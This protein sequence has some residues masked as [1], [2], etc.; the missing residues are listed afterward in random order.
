[1][2]KKQ[3][4]HFLQNAP[5]LLTWSIIGSAGAY[6]YNSIIFKY[7]REASTS[8]SRDFFLRMGFYIGV[9][10]VSIPLTLLFDR[11]F[12]NN[13]YVNKLYGKDI[14]NKDILTKAQM[15]KSGQA[16]FYIALLLFTT[17]SWW[18]FDT[19]GGNFNSWYR[20]YGQHL[21][22]LRSSSE[23]ARV[24]S[25]HSLASSGNSK[26][27]LMK[28]FADRL[29][30]GTKN[31][32]L[33]I[34]WLAGSNSLKHPDI[35]KEIQNGIKSNDASIKNNSILALTRIMEVPGIETVRF[36]EEELKKYLTA[37]KKP[38]VQ[39]V[40]A[41]AFLRTT[42]FINLFIDMFKINDETLSV[43]LS[44]AL[45]WVSGPTP[46]QISRIIRQLKHNISKGSERLK[47]MTTIALT[48]MAQSLDDESLA[49]LRREF[50]AKSSD[51]RCNPE[52]FSLHF[53]EKK[54]D[55]I[56]ITKL[57]IRGFTYPAHG[58]VHYR[59]RIL[60]ILALNRDDSM[61]PW[62]E[63][64]ANNENINEYLRGLAKQAAKR[65][66]NENQIADW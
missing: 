42:E 57:T 28:I 18:S 23:K 26:P 9:F 58:K 21:T 36:I 8:T 49:I 29:K 43:I 52:V 25:L 12:N 64:M 47:C 24:K 38:P 65:N 10:L 60:R 46:I 63:R 2:E 44:Y 16:Q 55:T 1:M 4:V 59:E 19:L 45:V 13:R 20:K 3:K 15:I 30:K 56:N 50:E 17:I 53:N 7:I 34:I 39:L 54:R 31:E 41:A 51:F 66:K 5:V 37:G 33:T 62:F 27:W 35:I 61:L 48:F 14:D 11:F 32:K 6:T 22:S 40:F